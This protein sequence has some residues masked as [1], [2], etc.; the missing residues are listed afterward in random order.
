[1]KTKKVSN[2]I[3]IRN[4][5]YDLCTKN[6]NKRN[7]IKH[8]L[9]NIIKLDITQQNKINITK[10]ASSIDYEMSNS[11]RNYIHLESFVVRVM[12]EL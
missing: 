4:I 12:N 8:I 7:I 3:K 5:L 11:Y 6:Y 9:L 1:M 2:I 10:I